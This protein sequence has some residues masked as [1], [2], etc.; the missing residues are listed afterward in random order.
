M[1]ATHHHDSMT[2]TL[3]ESFNGFSKVAGSLLSIHS[4]K[5][6]QKALDT[7]SELLEKATDTPDEALNPLIEMLSNSIERYENALPE[8][9]AWDKHVND[10]DAGAS[11][12]RLLISQHKLTYSDFKEDIGGK[13]YVSQILSGKKA[14]SKT[15]IDRLSKR[16][17]VSPSLFF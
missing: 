1:L 15:H 8:V 2:D 14:L 4:E 11:M 12:L 10:M 16:F 7:L 5:V 9:Q 13:S 3:L 17:N 6:Y